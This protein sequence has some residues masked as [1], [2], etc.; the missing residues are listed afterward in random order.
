MLYL[1]FSCTIHLTLWIWFKVTLIALKLHSLCVCVRVRVSVFICAYMCVCLCAC[2]TVHVREHV[3]DYY[4]W[5]TIMLVLIRI[6]KDDFSLSHKWKR[7]QLLRKRNFH[8]KQQIV[9]VTYCTEEQLFSIYRIFPYRLTDETPEHP[10]GSRVSDDTS[11]H[12][13]GGDEEISEHYRGPSGRDGQGRSRGGMAWLPVERKWRITLELPK[14]TSFTCPECTTQ[15]NVFSSLTRHLHIK[16]ST[17]QVEWRYK[18]C[19]CEESFSSRRDLGKHSSE[20][21]WP[22]GSPAIRHGDYPWDFCHE[23]SVS[24]RNKS[25]HEQNRHPIQLSKQLARLAVLEEERL[26]L[27]QPSQPVHW[28]IKVINSLI[29]AMFVV[30]PSN[31]K[32][33]H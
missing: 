10:R 1:S 4:R 31:F 14:Q 12:Y 23:L 29:S 17:L 6:G 20:R 32:D 27:S 11:E 9:F 19:D 30:L 28:S 13:H 22:S 33:L 5:M 3:Y 26:T 8:K 2:F 7:N 25:Q 16:H 21:H 24:Q 15:Y 18:C